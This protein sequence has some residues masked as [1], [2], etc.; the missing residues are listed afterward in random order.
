LI[1]VHFRILDWNLLKDDYIWK[2]H[3]H[4]FTADSLH[5]F[6]FFHFLLSPIFFHT[7][8]FIMPRVKHVASERKPRF[9]P[10]SHPHM[11][12]DACLRRLGNTSQR[13]FVPWRWVGYS[14]LESV[15]FTFHRF[16]DAQQVQGFLEFNGPV[17]EVGVK[18]F[19][20]H[21][22]YAKKSCHAK[23]NYTFLSFCATDLA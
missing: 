23:V 15:N 12:P 3:Y 22:F 14:W 16:F 2:K 11:A 5:L 18:E 13:D 10:A 9:D 21:I 4:L 20:A 1:N 19:Y 6:L 8:P 17:C 7:V